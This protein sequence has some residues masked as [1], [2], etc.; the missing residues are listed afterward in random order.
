MEVALPADGAPQPA[1]L[2]VLRAEVAPDGLRVLGSVGGARPVL[3]HARL[4][5]AD[6]ASLR[7]VEDR[8]LPGERDPWDSTFR[9]SHFA[10]AQ[11]PAG[12]EARSPSRVA[13]EGTETPLLLRYADPPEVLRI[14]LRRFNYRDLGERGTGDA[15][16][17]ARTLIGDLLARAPAAAAGP[18]ALAVLRGEPPPPLPS[19]EILLARVAVLG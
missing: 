14:D 7:L 9:R 18:G 2:Q 12:P 6:A 4:R 15:A 10:A 5:A 17:D 19:G 8:P 16:R 11:G 3:A 1:P 13:V